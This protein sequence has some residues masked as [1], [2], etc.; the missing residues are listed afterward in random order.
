MSDKILIVQYDAD[1][2]RIEESVTV[3]PVTGL[4]DDYIQ[5]AAGVNGIHTE[6]RIPYSLIPELYK[7][8]LEY[9][10]HNND[11]DVSSSY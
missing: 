4:Y 1:N 6:V 3:A 11:L 5:F 10:S 7:L 2:G 8:A 9:A